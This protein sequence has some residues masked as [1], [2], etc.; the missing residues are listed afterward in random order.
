MPA[1]DLFDGIN[2]VI[3]IVFSV[4]ALSERRKAHERH[5][6]KYVTLSLSKCLILREGKGQTSGLYD[7]N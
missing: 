6:N 5:P 3:K 2:T 4:A 1:P 7:E